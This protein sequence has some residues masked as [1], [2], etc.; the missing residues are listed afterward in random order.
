VVF[1]DAQLTYRELNK[2]ANQVAHYLRGRGIGPGSLVGISV[3]RSTEM[4]VGLLGILKAGVAYLPL[5]P[6]DPG[7]RIGFIL[8]DAQPGVLLTQQRFAH[9]IPLRPHQLLLIDTEWRQVEGLSEETPVRQGHA[10]SLAYVIYTS[11]ST[12]APRGVIVHSG[13]LT[14]HLLWMQSAFPLSREDKVLQKYPFNF[15]ASICEI[16]GSLLGAPA[17]ILRNRR[18][19]GMLRISSGSWWNIR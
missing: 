19:I 15:D 16:F 6:N 4:I 17:C 11:G 3:E 12:G 10:E 18:S 5:D 7:E 2:R 13:A 1:R 8:E 14:N 9:H